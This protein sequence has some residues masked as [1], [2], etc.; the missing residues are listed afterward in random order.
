MHSL[1]APLVV[2]RYATRMMEH[3][4]R[5][6]AAFRDQLDLCFLTKEDGVS[7]DAD[8]KR[9]TGVQQLASLHQKH[10]NQV[11]VVRAQTSRTEPADA[12]VTDVAGLSL[13]IRFADCQNFVLYTPSKHVVALVHAG[14]RGVVAGIIPA[15][16]RTLKTEWGIQPQDVLVGAGPSLCTACADFTDPATEVPTLASFTTGRTVDLI[17]AANAQFA[18]CGVPAANIERS[19][20]CTRCIPGTYWTYRGGHREEVKQGYTNCFVATLR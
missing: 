14:W 1:S 13:L 8:V 7:S 17:A 19:P 4:F 16:F 12:I 20:D 6:L 15:T 18:E 3:P 9:V 2:T 11:A 5:S 10:G